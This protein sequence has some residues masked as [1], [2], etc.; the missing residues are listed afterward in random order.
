MLAFKHEQLFSHK[1]VQLMNQQ[2][3]QRNVRENVIEWST[4]VNRLINNSDIMDEVMEDFQRLGITNNLERFQAYTMKEDW[5]PVGDKPYPTMPEVAYSV[6]MP[7]KEINKAAMFR[8]HAKFPTVTYVHNC[9]T[10][11]KG[12]GCAIFRSAEPILKL[13]NP[14]S[15]EDRHLVAKMAEKFSKTKSE[16]PRSLKAQDVLCIF[17]ARS[18]AQT[19]VPDKMT[20]GYENP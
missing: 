7:K 13:M 14:G 11:G 9:K 16:N 17:S 12:K 1:A 20:F 19:Q 4:R 5:V 3:E 18:F 15:E 10:C 6:V 2:V 8:K